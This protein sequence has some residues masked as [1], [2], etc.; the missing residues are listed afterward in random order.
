M[1][2]RIH[3]A[4]WIS[5]TILPAGVASAADGP[6][7]QKKLTQFQEANFGVHFRHSDAVTTTY[8]PHGGAAQVWIEYK[9]K[10]IGG[11]MIRPAP[12][13]SLKDFIESGKKH[14]QTKYG[15]SSVAYAPYNNPQHYTFHYLKT[16]ITHEKTNYVIERFVYLRPPDPKHASATPEEKIM[17]QISGAFSFEFI[18]SEADYDQIKPDIRT[19]IDTFELVD[20]SKPKPQ[21]K[22]P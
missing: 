1:P 17:K 6:A 7:L 8:N 3:L 11:L 18:C 12:P 5:L 13:G 22:S 2:K 20:V 4:F 19:V 16:R 10:P 15:S 21:P 14:Y 9:G